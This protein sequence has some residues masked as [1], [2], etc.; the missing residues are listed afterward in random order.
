VTAEVVY[1]EYTNT[2]TN[3]EGLVG[4]VGGSLICSDHEIAVRI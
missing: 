1:K 4:K 2:V 3:K